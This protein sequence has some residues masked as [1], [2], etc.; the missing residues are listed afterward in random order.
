MHAYSEASSLT[1]FWRDSLLKQRSERGMPNTEHEAPR[2]AKSI[3]TAIA[4][5][6]RNVLTGLGLPSGA[7]VS[8]TVFQKY[9]RMN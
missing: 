3:P 5:N 2:A 6:L 9:T 1:V 7:A 4:C 8:T